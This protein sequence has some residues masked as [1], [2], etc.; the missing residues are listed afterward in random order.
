MGSVVPAGRALTALLLAS[1]AVPRTYAGQ[2]PAPADAPQEAAIEELATTNVLEPAKLDEIVALLSTSYTAH[3]TLKTALR[4]AECTRSEPNCAPLYFAQD[5][6]LGPWNT[7]T[8]LRT[9]Q[10]LPDKDVA[11]IARPRDY[12]TPVLPPAGVL[13][14]DSV[15][16]AEY[17]FE[18]QIALYEQLEAWQ[19]TLERYSAAVGSNDESAAAM[20]RRALDAYSAQAS[21]AAAGVSAASLQ[22]LERLTPV[23]GAFGSVGIDDA[24]AA[25]ED[26][27]D[28]GIGPE[29]IERFS[30]LGIRQAD[31]NR[32]VE[33]IFALNEDAPVG[34]IEGL[35]AVA[36]AYDTLADVL[37]VP[38]QPAGNSRPVADAG[39]DQ[40]VPTD[41]TGFAAVMLSG[42]RSSDP[43]AVPLA[44]VW[45]VA[46]NAVAG[47]QPTLTLP[48]GIHHIALTVADGHGGTDVDIV[49]VTV[50]DAAAP[51]ISELTATPSVLWPPNRQLIL[52]TLDVKAVDNDDPAPQCQ[53]IS[54]GLNA[55][56]NTT[57][58]AT[59][60]DVVLNGS[61][62]VLLRADPSGATP[63]RAYTVT[64]QCTDKSNHSSTETV[65]VPVSH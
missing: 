25:K 47:A 21:T 60:P 11:T 2:D 17:T 30:A 8:L 7:A 35:T 45:T 10:E 54:V 5:V 58:A 23:L 22:L 65:F 61:L 9:I 48:P 59:E 64:V 13:P 53:V 55:P 56:A 32:L 24:A 40:A 57:G 16:L 36:R 15:S 37:T 18:Q 38:T 41:E 26:L 52:V 28:R 43:E 34:L 20:Q 49:T 46:T 44:Y 4:T 50:G 29:V 19:T 31:S 3:L 33:E 27:R 14:P 1:L 6:I 39:P 51:I 42:T 63:G 12:E 62:T